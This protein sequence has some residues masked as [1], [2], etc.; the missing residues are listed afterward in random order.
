[1]RKILALLL[2]LLAGVATAQTRPCGMSPS[3]WCPAPPGDPCGRH[4]NVQEC[5]ADPACEGMQY[6]GLSRLTCRPDGNGFWVNCPA[7]GCLSGLEPNA[8]PH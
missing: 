7:V 8:R 1:M 6:K 3:D 5:R 4:H 2:L